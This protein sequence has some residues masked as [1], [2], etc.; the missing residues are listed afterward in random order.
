LPQNI[1][2]DNLDQALNQTLFGAK[3]VDFSMGYFSLWGRNLFLCNLD[4][5]NGSQLDERFI[6]IKKTNLTEL[7]ENQQRSV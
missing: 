3:R 4:Q 7:Y 6:V 2:G 1:T 5:L